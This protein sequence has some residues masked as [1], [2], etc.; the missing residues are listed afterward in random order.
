[1]AF[2][3]CTVHVTDLERSVKFYEDVVGLNVVRRLPGP[4]GDI[5]FLSA[6]GETLLELMGGR[7]C[8]VDDDISIGF[9]TDDLD[10]LTEE[11]YAKGVKIHSGPFS[12]APGVRFLFVQ[13]PDGLMMQFVEQTGRQTG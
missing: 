10:A 3:W 1:M 11:L 2:L 12:P 13:D 6:G 9:S 7:R 8:D 4:Y 5:V